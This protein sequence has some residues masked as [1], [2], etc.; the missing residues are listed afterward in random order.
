MMQKKGSDNGDEGYDSEDSCIYTP[1]TSSKPKRS[2]TLLGRV[3]RGIEKLAEPEEGSKRSGPLTPTGPGEMGF[4]YDPNKDNRPTTGDTI[5]SN[6]DEA[7]R[8][9][10]P[11]HKN[12]HRKDDMPHSGEMGRKAFFG[13]HLRKGG[14]KEENREDTELLRGDE[15][16]ERKFWYRTT[17]KDPKETIDRSRSKSP[18][19]NSGGGRQN[20]SSSQ[21]SSLS[22]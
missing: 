17:G 14:G 19:N 15:M 6:P 12:L 7:L 20:R 8:V 13:L 1:S 2:P 18:S 9:S 11:K 16:A 3:L 22:A 4:K 21:D 5:G 10:T